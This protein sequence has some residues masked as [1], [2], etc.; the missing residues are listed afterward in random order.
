M[1]DYAN[2]INKEIIDGKT[3]HEGETLIFSDE[4]V[5]FKMPKE[6]EVIS[7]VKYKYLF[8]LAALQAEENAEN[9]AT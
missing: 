8:A 9:P 1:P 6:F 5:N 2:F 4:I 7:E 3:Y